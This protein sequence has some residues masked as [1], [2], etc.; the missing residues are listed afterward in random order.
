MQDGNLDRKIENSELVESLGS[1][2]GFE[3]GSS[4]D[5]LDGNIGAKIEEYLMGESLVS[6][7]MTERDPY[8]GFSDGGVD[9]KLGARRGPPTVS[10]RAGSETESFYR[11]NAVERG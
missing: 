9:G 6:E 11:S 7:I 8:D 4:D 1:E 2:F 5:I 3:I 10:A